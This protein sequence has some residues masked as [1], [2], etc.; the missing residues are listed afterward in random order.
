[1]ILDDDAIVWQL[2]KEYMSKTFS[3][4]VILTMFN[5]SFNKLP[6]QHHIGCIMIHEVLAQASCMVGEY[7]DMDL[8]IPCNL[9]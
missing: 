6:S 9:R 1:M 7:R 5:N 4:V 2:M 8:S 3:Y